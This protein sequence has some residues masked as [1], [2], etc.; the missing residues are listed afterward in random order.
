MKKER[1]KGKEQRK[2]KTKE[3]LELNK[4]IKREMKISEL[5]KKCPELTD[6]FIERQHFCT[7]CPAAAAECLDDFCKANNIDFR[8]LKQEMLTFLKRKIKK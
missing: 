2:E 1:K 4:I 8:K 6:F 3:I 5:I 7:F